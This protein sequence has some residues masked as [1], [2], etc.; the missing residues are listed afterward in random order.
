M[1]LIKLKSGHWG[2]GGKPAYKLVIKKREE[3]QMTP[4][5]FAMHYGLD[6]AAQYRFERGDNKSLPLLLQELELVGYS[7]SI[8]VL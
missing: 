7:V 3:M 6:H 8:H 1:K 2:T 4:Y 5:Q